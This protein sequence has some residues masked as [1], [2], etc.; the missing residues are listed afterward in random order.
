MN[1]EYITTTTTSTNNQNINGLNNN[2]TNNISNQ[3]RGTCYLI[4]NNLVQFQNDSTSS[5][6]LT[7]LQPAAVYTQLPSIDTLGNKSRHRFTSENQWY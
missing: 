1:E 7:E 6:T 2:S 3:N 5:Q 4:G